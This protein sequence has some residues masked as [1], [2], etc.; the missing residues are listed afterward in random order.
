MI[1]FGYKYDSTDFQ[2]ALLY[3][4]L[5]RIE[6]QHKMRTDVFERYR[7]AFA[8]VPGIDFPKIAQRSVYSGH[9]FAIWVDPEK[10]DHIRAKLLEKGIDTSIHFEA[11]HLEPYY[12]KHFGFKKGMFPVAERLGAS[13]ITLPTYGKLSAE[14]QNYVIKNVLAL[15]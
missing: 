10:R 14:E 1:T 12:R 11:I 8:G 13:V 4:Q 6:K 5:K 2:A 7:K 9:M 15:V 3:H